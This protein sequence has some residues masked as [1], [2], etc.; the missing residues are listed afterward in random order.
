MKTN[1]T[2][3]Q[4]N[5]WVS[6]QYNGDHCNAHLRLELKKQNKPWLNAKVIVKEKDF[7][8][9]VIVKAG[10][11]GFEFRRHNLFLQYHLKDLDLFAAHV[12]DKG[13]APLSLGTFVAAAVYK[14]KDHAVIV[15]GQWQKSTGKISATIGT[16]SKINKNTEVRA[17][18]TN[19]GILSLVAKR[20][21]N[22]NLSVLVGT[23]FNLT[24]PSASIKSHRAVPIPLGVNLEFT[25]N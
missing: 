10:L 19:A 5:G 4:F 23:E 9:G 7:R 6:G 13:D 12:T 15:R 1:N 11:S 8:A 25:Y 20:V 18:V 24:D 3:S 16:H 17:K 14:L 22:H 21:H 2:F